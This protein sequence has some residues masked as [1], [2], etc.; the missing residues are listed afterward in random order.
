[1]NIGMLYVVALGALQSAS[2][3]FIK[4]VTRGRNSSAAPSSE[5]TTSGAIPFGAT[6]SGGATAGYR[7]GGASPPWVARRPSYQ[8]AGCLSFAAASMHCYL[9]AVGEAPL[10]Q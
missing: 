6:T 3:N 2:Y 9:K 8:R 5:A 10:S 7:Y 1:M 4:C